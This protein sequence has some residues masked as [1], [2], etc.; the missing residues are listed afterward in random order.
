ML[1]KVSNTL[2]L[3]GTLLSIILVLSTGF[4][5]LYDSYKDKKKENVLERLSMYNK[6]HF[7]YSPNLVVEKDLL[8]VSAVIPEEVYTMLNEISADEVNI[9]KSYDNLSVEI[10]EPE[11]D[12]DVIS[13]KL[14]DYVDYLCIKKDGVFYYATS[15]DGLFD[16]DS[17]EYI[18]Y[19]SNNVDEFIESLESFIVNNDKLV[20]FTD[21]NYGSIPLTKKLCNS[22]SKVLLDESIN[23]TDKLLLE[24]QLIDNLGTQTNTLR[25]LINFERN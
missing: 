5:I 2:W 25:N 21:V 7:D 24:L 16:E 9:L 14:V 22:L 4:I 19:T 13:N 17:V 10:I 18:V 1:K 12:V 15:E 8:S 23:E 6:V 3:A 20:I 11:K